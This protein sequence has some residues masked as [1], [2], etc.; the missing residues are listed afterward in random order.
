MC[1]SGSVCMWREND[2]SCAVGARMWC[3]TLRNSTSF[4]RLDCSGTGK[5]KAWNCGDAQQLQDAWCLSGY[6]K[7]IELSCE[8]TSLTGHPLRQDPKFPDFYLV[9]ECSVHP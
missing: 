4:G 8:V 3:K 9:F 7:R 1:E 6:C 5:K 2:E